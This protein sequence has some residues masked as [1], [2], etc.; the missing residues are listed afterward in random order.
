MAGG[1]LCWHLCIASHHQSTYTMHACTH[2]CQPGGV[3]GAVAGNQRLQDL[4]ALVGCALFCSCLSVPCNPDSGFGIRQ[5]PTQFNPRTFC[6]CRYLAVNMQQLKSTHMLHHAHCFAASPRP[7]PK[8]PVHRSPARGE[9]P[10]LAP[11]CPLP[12]FYPACD[13]VPKLP[14]ASWCLAATW[15]SGTGTGAQGQVQAGRVIH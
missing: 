13:L 8:R 11:D 12:C 7:I 15:L 2:A 6:S 3:A 5:C 9:K 1:L 4:T 10:S 14:C